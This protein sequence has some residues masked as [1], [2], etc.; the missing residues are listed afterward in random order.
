MPR[1]SIRYNSPSYSLQ[2]FLAALV[3]TFLLT[4]GQ[5]R[6][7][8]NFRRIPQSIT[9]GASPRPL[10]ACFYLLKILL[11]FFLAYFSCAS[12]I[13]CTP[14]EYL[15]LSRYTSTPRL[16]IKRLTE[17]LVA[18]C[19]ASYCLTVST[20]SSAPAFTAVCIQHGTFIQQLCINFRQSWENRV[21]SQIRI[22][23]NHS[24]N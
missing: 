9:A 23:T 14:A 22:R 4:P 18:M 21:S 10:T 17:R 15:R 16:R 6:S 3:V 24:T 7:I 20:S 8:S 2:L 19:H 12:C 13:R 1:I 11:Q 5:C